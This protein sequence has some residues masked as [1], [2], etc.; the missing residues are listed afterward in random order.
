[1]H[2]ELIDRIVR[3]VPLLKIA[4]TVGDAVGRIVDSGLPALP[5]VDAEDRLHG[6]F[7]ER[8][9][10]AALFPA[11]LSELKYAGFVRRSLDAM[12]EKRSGCL[13]D[14][15]AAYMNREHVQVPT[16]FSD[17]QAAET[18]LHHRVLILPI[19]DA[20]QR[21]RGVVSRTDFFVALIARLDP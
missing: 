17:L 12:L 6:I 3:D 18:F 4:D 1:M 14:P 2:A 11:Y 19:V 15:V 20:D 5:V 7:G 8:E 16:G 13:A 21:V 9:M 10:M